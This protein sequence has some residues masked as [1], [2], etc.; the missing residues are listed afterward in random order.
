[1][2]DVG[3][4]VVDLDGIYD[5]TLTNDRLLLGVKGT[6]SEFELNL[7]RQRS[8]EAILR[9]LAVAN[10]K[11]RF[12]SVSVGRQAVNWKKIPT[13]VCSKPF[14]WFFVKMIELGSVRQVLRW[15]REEN[16]LLPAFLMTLANA[17]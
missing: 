4:V 14:S 12:L 2:W 6:I 9:K 5:P 7:F 8:T 16:I 13:S 1:M 15:F 11:F 10:C 17:R 3:A